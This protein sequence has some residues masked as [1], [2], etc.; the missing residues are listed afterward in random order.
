MKMKDDGRRMDDGCGMMK[1]VL[2]ISV[3]RIKRKS[4]ELRFN[5]NN[6]TK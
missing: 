3:G 5:N 1:K 6:I 2:L 4:E